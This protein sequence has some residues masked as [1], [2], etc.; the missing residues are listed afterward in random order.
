MKRNRQH[1]IED[2]SENILRSLIPTEWVLRKLTPDYGIDYNVEIFEGEEATGLHFFLQLKGTDK[3]EENGNISFQLNKKYIEYYQKVALPILFVYVSVKS[4]K[5]WA[6]WLNRCAINEKNKSRTLKFTANDILTK[7][8]IT[9]IKDNLSIKH[10]SIKI[11]YINCDNNLYTLL[12]KWIVHFFKENLINDESKIADEI[13]INLKKISD[14]KILLNISDE[15]FLFERQV[16]LPNNISDDLLRL[17]EIDILPNSL[18]NFFYEFSKILL[19]RNSDSAIY[20]LLEILPDLKFDEFVDTVSVIS[21]CVSK[22][23]YHEIEQLGIATIRKANFNLFQLIY[24]SLFKY[25]TNNRV[26]QIKE[27]LLLEAIQKFDDERLTGM[28][29]YNL[30]NHYQ[31]INNRKKQFHTI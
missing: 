19:V 21:K 15:R 23:L 17:P 24:I 25:P 31:N 1:I 11:K 27:N 5:V 2:E 22:K 9:N 20:T 8:K 16:E 12:N 4:K 26:D 30:A 18:N 14:D 6:K 13:V 3:T 10:S 28:F 29:H 7:G